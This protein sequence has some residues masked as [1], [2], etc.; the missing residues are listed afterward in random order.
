MTAEVTPMNAL[1]QLIV[2][3]IPELNEAEKVKIEDALSGDVGVVSE[4]VWDAIGAMED[5]MDELE[6]LAL[7]GHHW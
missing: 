7:G 1:V 6:R 2:A 5:R 4:R 3:R